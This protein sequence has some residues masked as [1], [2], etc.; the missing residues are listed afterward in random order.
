VI[1]VA[2]GPPDQ[3]ASAIEPLA[4][5]FPITVVDNSSRPDTRSLVEGLGARYLDPG[6]NLGFGAGVNFALDRRDDLER[7]VLLLNPDARISADDVERMRSELGRNSRLA[8]VGPDQVDEAG[9]AARVWW[10]FPSPARAWIDNLGLG[11]GRTRRGF[12]IGSILLIR[13][14]AVAAVG[15]FDER[16]FLYAEETDWQRRAVQAGWQIGLVAGTT[17]V[18]IGAGTGGDPGARTQLPPF[19]RALYPKALRP[20]R[21]GRLPHCGHLRRAG[22]KRWARS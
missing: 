20:Q 5:R 11:R 16:F 8:C 1:V 19:A 6:R 17:A 10:P 21:M 3:L 2:Y 13:A 7:D 18:H 12:A 14:Q 4:G 22:P 15:R 9:H